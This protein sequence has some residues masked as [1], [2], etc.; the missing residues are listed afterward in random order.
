ML[1]PAVTMLQAA[2]PA[3]PIFFDPEQ[4]RLELA[5]MGAA[6]RD[7]L[8]AA[9]RK[10]WRSYKAL[11]TV[12]DKDEYGIDERAEPFAMSVM[13]AAA[14]A[15]GLDNKVARKHLVGILDRWADG[16]A[17]SKLKPP[18]PS[19][20]YAVDRSLLP[21]II[22]YWLTHDAPEMS[23]K[24]RQRIYA[25]IDG[26]VERGAVRRPTLDP[27]SRV[28]NNNH[29]YLNAS[30]IMAWSAMNRDADGLRIGIDSFRSAIDAMR[31]DGSLPL[32]TDR[33]GRALWYQRHAI[34]SLVTIA[35]IAAAN[36]IDLYALEDNGRSLHQ[37]IAFLLNGIDDPNIVQ[38]YAQDNASPAP[39]TDPGVQDLSFLQ[40]RGHG[41]HYMAWAEPYMRRF[42]EHPNTARLSKLLLDE[43]SARPMSD[44]YSGGNMSCLFALTN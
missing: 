25:W 34:A 43:P 21:V 31:E 18:S 35:E 5:S 37:A 26:L 8:C 7:A 28:A 39:G 22:A 29:S 12:R 38:P 36:D 16:R 15:Y 20:F 24:K 14:E 13:D 40:E 17:F 3:G 2:E 32:E 41:R 27:K 6:Q 19:A 42:P 23:K 9:E 30:V 4:R 33:G 10:S 11:T 1:L 44:D